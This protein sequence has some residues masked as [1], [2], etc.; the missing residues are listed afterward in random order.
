MLSATSMMQ[1]IAAR[2]SCCPASTSG[3]HQPTVQP[4]RPEGIFPIALIWGVVEGGSTSY[5][6][7]MFCAGGRGR[8]L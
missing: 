8:G 6:L 4:G 1:M 3:V 5:H 2:R 7:K